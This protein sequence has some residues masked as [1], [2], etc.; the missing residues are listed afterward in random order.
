MADFRS[1][2]ES[3]CGGTFEGA[4]VSDDPEDESWRREAL[5]L[6]PVICD[7]DKMA[8]PLAVGQDR[9]RV[10]VIKPKGD[11][12]HFYHIH[13]HDGV[14][15]AVSRYG[16]LS[17]I[18][19]GVQARFPADKFSQDLFRREGLEVSVTNVWRFDIAPGELLAYE[20]NREGRHFRAEF[21]LTTAP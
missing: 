2:M 9:S 18:K 10:W 17:V 8:M 7:S 14:E 19:T 5:V 1:N 11:Q 15:D 12:L 6:G 21:D 3:L 13:G 4:V 20:L 16:G